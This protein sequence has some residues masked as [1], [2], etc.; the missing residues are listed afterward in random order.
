MDLISPAMRDYSAIIP[1]RRRPGLRL[2]GGRARTGRENVCAE[3]KASAAAAALRY[4][5]LARRGRDLRLP[6]VTVQLNGAVKQGTDT[7]SA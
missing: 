3:S 7:H 1:D 2:S 5:R 6:S 4:R